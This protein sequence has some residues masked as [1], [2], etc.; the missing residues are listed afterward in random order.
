M[1]VCLTSIRTNYDYDETRKNLVQYR[2][3][4]IAF[5]SIV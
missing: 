3:I 4:G 5:Y 2:I 1:Q